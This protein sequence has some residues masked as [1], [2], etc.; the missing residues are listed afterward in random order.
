MAEL[1]SLYLLLINLTFTKAGASE[2]GSVERW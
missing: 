2:S 1:F